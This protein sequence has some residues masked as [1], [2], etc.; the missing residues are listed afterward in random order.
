MEYINLGSFFPRGYDVDGKLMLV[1]IGKAYVKGQ[2]DVGDLK[3]CVLYWCERLFR[4]NDFDQISVVFDMQ[5]CGLSNM[6]MDFSRFIIDIFKNYYPNSLNY[7]LIYE[8]PW[9]LNAA[10]KII[11]QLLPQK[12]ASRMKF[13][14]P[15]NIREFMPEQHMLTI[16]GGPDDY[17]FKFVEE[18]SKKVSFVKE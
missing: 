18:N 16:W 10:F 11:K 9:I 15:K 3:M 6:D 2:F 14:Y 8:M 1:F 4:E 13:I 17:V 5:K 7:I 12:S